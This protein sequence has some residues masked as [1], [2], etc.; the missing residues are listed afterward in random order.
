M[1]CQVGQ[2]CL[3]RPSG[4]KLLTNET[5]HGY[6]KKTEDTLYTKLERLMYFV[7]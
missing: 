2:N 7:K 6:L 3:L 5:L 1:C 4:A